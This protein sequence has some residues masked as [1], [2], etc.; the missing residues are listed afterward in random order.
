MTSSPYDMDSGQRKFIYNWWGYEIDPP[1]D[2]TKAEARYGKYV[3]DREDWYGIVE[4]MIHCK[5]TRNVF[6]SLETMANLY[7]LVTGISMTPDELRIAGQRVYTLE[8]A[9]NVREG[10]TRQDDY[11]PP[12]IFNDPVPTGP[13]KGTRLTKQEYDMMLDAYYKYRDWTN[14]GIPTK[15]KLK[16]LGLEDVTKDLWGKNS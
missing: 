14:E 2:G 12:R 13:F 8:K 1:V 3:A 7:T 16:S 4:S 9:F 6:L 5:F 10:W 15:E 11:P